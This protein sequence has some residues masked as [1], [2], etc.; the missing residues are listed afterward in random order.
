[1]ST[2]WSSSPVRLPDCGVDHG[3]RPGTYDE[4]AR[5]AEHEELTVAR[6]L[7]GEGHDVTSLRADRR[8]GP[9]ADFD[10]CG[11]TVEVKSLVAQAERAGG[12]AAND[13]SGYNRLAAS[14]RQAEVTI[15]L[16]TGSGLSAVDAAAGVR[17]FAE[18]G[19]TGRVQA[20]RILGDGYDLAWSAHPGV[21][22][23]RPGRDRPES[24][25]ERTVR[26]TRERPVAKPPGADVERSGARPTRDRTEAKLPTADVE[27]SSTRPISDRA[28]GR[29]PAREVDKPSRAAHQRPGAEPPGLG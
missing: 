10:V 25:V 21:E 26:P 19:R 7:V 29:R 3:G 11:L 24:Q 2:R 5:R 8:S 16:A 18:G 22:V 20:V 12:R 9:T 27:R 23:S 13:R 4:S 1:M 6:V 17:R 15:L 28:E 14:S